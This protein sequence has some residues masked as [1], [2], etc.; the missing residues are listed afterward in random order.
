VHPPDRVDQDGSRPSSYPPP[1][2]P[3]GHTWRT[4]LVLAVSALGWAE[5]APLQW[6]QARALFW[7]DLAAGLVTFVLMF[8]R[9][10]HPLGV[11]AAV[12]LAGALSYSSAGPAVLVTVSLATRRR[13]PEIVGVGV[14]GIVAA[15][16]FVAYQPVP[17]SP[18]WVSVTL[19]LAVTVALAALGMFIGSQRELMWTLQDRARRAEEQQ[20]ARVAQARAAERE[21]IAREMHDVLAHRISLVAMH[22]G[23][24][25]YR[26]DLEPEAVRSSAELIQTQA[27]EALSDLRLV[28]GVLRDDTLSA[29]ET[30]SLRPQPTLADLL[31]LVDEARQ[32]GMVVTLRADHAEA[33][34]DS[35]GRAVY[36]VV[37]EG[38]TN[39]RKHAPHA[40]ADVEVTL[41][42][43]AVVVTVSN[44]T[45]V[46][47]PQVPGAGLG[48]I[49]LRERVDLAGGVLE[50]GTSGQRFVLRA[51]LP[52]HREAAPAALA[53]TTPSP[54]GSP[55]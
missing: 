39:A 48:L 19:L 42:P 51:T 35:L 53:G 37:Q 4:V 13:L 5:L 14:L 30:T 25:T 46:T 26:T 20:A 10:R 28:L 16:V 9:R 54:S 15:F 50:H 43:D 11:A 21:R 44:A 32:A 23:A 6:S 7:L 18:A 38:L 17:P 2:T 41:G 3:W 47:E 33:V 40:H 29:E 45:G 24:L 49:G 31:C 55:A 12:T 52:L 36:R 8:F 34:P 1:I 27:H 22:A